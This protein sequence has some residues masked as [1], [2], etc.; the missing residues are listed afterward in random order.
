MASTA[1][2]PEIP[3]FRLISIL[4][5]GGMGCVYLAQHLDL[6]R[7]VALK[8][9]AAAGTT[10]PSLLSRFR[11]E[12]RAVAAVTHPGV[13]HI[14]EAGESKGLPYLAME[15]VEGVTLSE[16]LRAQL[17]SPT[18]SAKSI[19]AIS[20]A[21]EACHQAGILHRDL[22]PSNVMQAKDGHIKV[23]DFG[24]AKRLHAGDEHKTQ[25]GE[26]IGTPSYMA[27]EQASGVVKQFSPATDV[28]AIGAILYELLT[29]RPPFQT[30]DLM[31][32]IMLVL[33]EEPISPRKLQPRV[34]VDLETICLKCLEKKPQKRYQSAADLA[35]D[36]RRFL[37]HRPVEARRTPFWEKSWK[38]ARR[39]PVYTVLATVSVLTLV[40][41]VLGV[42]FHVERLEVALNRSERLFQGSQEL[43]RWLVNEH[44]PQIA[45]LRGGSTQQEELVSKTLEHLQQLEQD[46]AA[47]RTLAEYIA[48]AYLRIAEIQSDPFFATDVRLQQAVESY[49]NTLQLYEDLEQHAGADA[50]SLRKP[51]AEILIRLAQLNQQLGEI[52]VAREEVHKASELLAGIPQPDRNTRLLTLKAG[53][54]TVL[55]DRTQ[56][57]S[58]ACLDRC[59]KLMTQCGELKKFGDDPALAELQ[60]Q[61]SLL[62]A[63]VVETSQPGTFANS[64]R[65]V[66]EHLEDA[67][68]YFDEPSQQDLHVV[69]QQA[70]T[71]SRLA[72]VLDTENQQ[73]KADQLLEQAIEQ[74]QSLANEIPESPVITLSLL[75]FLEQRLAL[76]IAVPDLDAAL[77]TA[78]V[79]QQ[80]SEKLFLSNPKEF[81]EQFQRSHGL[82]ADVQRL[83]FRYDAA[84]D[85]LREAIELA[86]NDGSRQQQAILAGLLRAYAELLAEGDRQHSTV[87]ERLKSL[88]QAVAFLN[89]SLEIYEKLETATQSPSESPY[90]K[91]VAL[92]H[93]LETEMEQLKLRTLERGRTTIPPATLDAPKPVQQKQR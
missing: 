69:W 21:I 55:L 72:Q 44:I 4:G 13:C 61:L 23:M 39:H 89:E 91:S 90:W 73:K 40:A 19:L 14:Y 11:E 75:K 77:Q 25:T 37:E 81:R 79:H 16:A 63:D 87:P 46:V 78:Q 62:M 83:R 10:S 56:L 24:L 43:G 6:E 2:L 80:F 42:S 86:R 1:P 82:L 71:R 93:Q 35:E 70:Q 85:H 74:Q 9:V 32:T 64:M 12:S 50:V 31:Q 65:L 34:P 47:D 67:I 88:Q 51:R 18:E 33:T 5:Q 48:Q 54:L 3:G 57:S 7:L 36:I 22:K 41:A 30:P 59:Q 76:E 38:W 26:I 27:P 58:Q 53:W 29:G 17:P 92:K 28:Y 8:V 84:A 66:S 60:A 52:S 45:R 49:R 20:E 15:Y 68:S